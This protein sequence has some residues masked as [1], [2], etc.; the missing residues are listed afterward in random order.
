MLASFSLTIRFTILLGRSHCESAGAA[1]AM[2]A[3]ETRHE[4]RKCTVGRQC[5]LN[6]HARGSHQD[7][8]YSSIIW[9][10]DWLCK[11]ITA[12]AYWYS[13]H[14][15]TSCSWSQLVTGKEVVA[16][17]MTVSATWSVLYNILQSHTSCRCYQVFAVTIHPG[18]RMPRKG[19]R[20]KQP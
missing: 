6:T 13:N 12:E 16:C 11:V 4:I 14:I 5:L 3:T 19:R 8:E 2:F 20:V 10:P 9:Q 17:F 7:Q 15:Q 18:D 1:A